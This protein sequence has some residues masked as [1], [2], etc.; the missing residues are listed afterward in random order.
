MSPAGV[1]PGRA[2]GVGQDKASQNPLLLL[3]QSCHLREKEHTLPCQASLAGP[4]RLHG[5]G[6]QAVGGGTLSQGS[7]HSLYCGALG[8]G[9]KESMSSDGLEGQ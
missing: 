2:P 6:Y 4:R 8:E 3:Y 9:D 5:G 1:R 7:P